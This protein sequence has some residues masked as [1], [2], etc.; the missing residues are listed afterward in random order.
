MGSFQN[1]DTKSGVSYTVNRAETQCD[2]KSNS[3]KA[4]AV[5]S[6]HVRAAM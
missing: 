4:L 6:R 2:N 5:L 1:G 3:I